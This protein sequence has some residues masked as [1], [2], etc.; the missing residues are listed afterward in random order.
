MAAQKGN[1]YAEGQ[2]RPT[3]EYNE[4]LNKRVFKYALLG[5]TDKQIAPLFDIS[6]D[7]FYEWKKKYLSFSESLRKGKE[8]ADAKVVKALYK[9]ATGYTQKS[10]KIFQFQGTP[11]RV[12]FDEI[13]V[14]DVGAAKIWL[15]N[16]QRDNWSE[17]MDITSKGEKI[18]GGINL[19]T[20]DSETLNK[21]MELQEKLS[22]TPKSDE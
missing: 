14:P 11:V 3:K 12:P 18:E 6:E 15:T 13:I 10:E 1:K 7:T 8:D 9:R 4:S 17:R 5:L 21:L 22:E 19:A 2:G 20:L 16:R